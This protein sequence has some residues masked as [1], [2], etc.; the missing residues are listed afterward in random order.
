M[1]TNVLCGLEPQSVFSY[2]EQLTRIPRG[3]GNEKAVSDYIIAYAEQH[4]YRWERDE[5]N[6][7][8]LYAPATSGYENRKS[9]VLQA[10]LDMVCAKDPDVAFDFKT[11]PIDIYVE[12]GFVKAHGTTLGAD[13]GAGV[14]MILALLDDRTLPHPPVQAIF[15][16]G[17]EILFVG[18]EAMDAHWLDGDYYIGLDYSNNKK[19][20][21]SAAGV[22]VLQCTLTLERAPVPVGWTA[23]DV[24][25]SGMQ[26]GHSGNTI[27]MDRGNAVKVTEE[28]LVGLPAGLAS[29]ADI[30]AGTLINIIPAHA[31]AVVVCPPE[32]AD[33]VRTAL[34]ARIALLKEVYRHTEPQLTITV[35]QRSAGD[36]MTVLT[37]ACAEKLLRFVRL[38]YVGAWRTIPTLERSALPIRR[39][40]VW[41]RPRQNLP[42]LPAAIPN[43]CTIRLLPIS[44][45]WLPCAAGR[46]SWR[47]AQALGSTTRRLSCCRRSFPSS[48]RSPDASRRLRRSMPVWRA[49][50]LTPRPV[51]SGAGWIW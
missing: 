40:C 27:H 12:D 11:Q 34:D 22:S 47:A 46:L 8:K 14:A 17:E 41:N 42:F 39:Y 19:I 15:T 4:G 36:G 5:A 25:I 2:F 23:F 50:F 30:S 31:E 13:D 37:P 9:I 44:R 51:R 45:S 43:I 35:S 28:F 3:S 49:A 10:H 48:G 16:T 1:S 20:L 24:T 21:V 26:G 29:L 33:T 18:A 32:H 7:V 38:C 6:N